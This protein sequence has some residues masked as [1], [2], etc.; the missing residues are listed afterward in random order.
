MRG[1]D[2]V[3]VDCAQV[4]AI[5]AGYDGDREMLICI[6]QDVQAAYNYLPRAA[7]ERISAVLDIPLGQ[8]FGVAT[9]FRAF[10]LKPRGRHI[11]S[12]CLGT[13]CHVKGAA[14][15][16]DKIHRELGITPGETTA[17]KEFTLE[18]VRCVGCCSLAPVIMIGEDTYGNLTQDDLATILDNYRTLQK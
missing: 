1:G 14:G 15:V 5:I 18:T 17:D 13:A 12:V 4:D 10:S 8:I 9:F 7:L 3:E 6:L 16:Q 11:V 2:A